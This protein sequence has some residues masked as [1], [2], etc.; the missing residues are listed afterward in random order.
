MDVIASLNEA[1]GRAEAVITDPDILVSACTDWCGWYGGRALALLRP[2]DVAEVQRAVAACA[3][4]GV[5][6]VP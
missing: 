3:R 1:L 6:L 5:P 4:L 2:R